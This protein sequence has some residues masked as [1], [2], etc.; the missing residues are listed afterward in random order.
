MHEVLDAGAAPVV[1]RLLERIEHEVGRQRRGDPPADDAPREDV[2]HERDVHEAAPGGDVGEVRHPEL[3][4]PRRGEVA[5][6]EIG[7]PV[8]RRIADCVV[9]IQARP[10]TT[11]RRPIARIR[12]SHAAARHAE[13]FAAQLPPDLPR[14]VDLLVLVARCAE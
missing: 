10:R 2:D 4:R 12:R 11:P 13:A 9:I 5:I 6:D 8:G 7:R 3:I 14:P 1:D